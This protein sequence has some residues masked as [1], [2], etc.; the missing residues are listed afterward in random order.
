[1]AASNNMQFYYVQLLLYLAMIV[2]IQKY[3]I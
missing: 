3:L 2:G 1:M